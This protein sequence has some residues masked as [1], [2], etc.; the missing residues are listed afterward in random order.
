MWWLPGLLFEPTK[1]GGL[2]ISVHTD[3]EC[4]LIRDGDDETEVLSVKTILDE[5]PV[6]V[7]VGHGPHDN[8][9]VDKNNHIWDFIEKEVKEGLE[10]KQTGHAGQKLGQKGPKSSK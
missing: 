8:A 10:G 3:I 2:G 6:R 4:I 9:K 7:V 5:I 1:G